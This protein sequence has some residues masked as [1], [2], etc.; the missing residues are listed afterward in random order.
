[1]DQFSGAAKA[2]SSGTSAGVF[3]AAVGAG[4]VGG[5]MMIALDPPR[6]KR[7]MLGQAIVACIGSAMFGPIAV[8]VANHYLPWIDLANADAITAIEVSGPVFFVIG[9]LSWGLAGAVVHLRRLIA[10]KGAD[11]VADKIG[12][13][14]HHD[15]P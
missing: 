14:D 12:L 15:Q 8:R 13:K 2:A 3:G 9:S 4:L 6:T 5:L 1:M 10:D 7:Q 11:A